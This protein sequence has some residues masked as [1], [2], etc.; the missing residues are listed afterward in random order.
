MSPTETA[1]PEAAANTEAR[2]LAAAIR[3]AL[4]LPQAE[5]RHDDKTRD[6]LLGV[7]VA[8]VTGALEAFL[9]EGL[10]T[11]ASAASAIRQTTARYP[12]LYRAGQPEQHADTPAAAG[13]AG[14]LDRYADAVAREL[15]KARVVRGVPAVG[16][17]GISI[18]LTDISAVLTWGNRTGWQVQRHTEGDEPTFRRYMHGGL[19]LSPRG[20]AGELGVWLHSPDWLSTTAPDYGERSVN[21]LNA[22]LD[23]VVTAAQEPEGGR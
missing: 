8:A 1:A 17:A 4:D 18:E 6:L 19:V 15:S 21:Y 10:A 7:R 3:D 22:V 16:A 11:T 12:V 23:Q 9:G 5:T 14:P 2:E 13:E 20:V